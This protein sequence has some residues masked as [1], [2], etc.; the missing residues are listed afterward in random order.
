VCE[1]S[2]GIRYLLYLSEDEQGKE[3]HYLIDR[4]NDF[5]LNRNTG[6]H[7]PTPED[8]VNFH[9]D[10]L[11][12]G[13]LVFDMEGDTKVPRFLLFDCLVIDGKNI[14]ERSLDKRLAYMRQHL[15]QPYKK[16]FQVFPHELKFQPFEVRMKDM[17]LGYGME[18]M[19]KEVLPKLKHGNDGLI[20]TCRTTPY[21]H[22][23]DPHILKWKPPEEN[24][25][26]CRLKLFFPLIQPDEDDIA[27][28]WTEPYHDYHTLEHAEIWAFMGNGPN[29]YQ[30][31][32]DLH[33]T[34]EEFDE[35][36]SLGDPIQDRIVEC[37]QDEAGR[38][39]I[40]RF[41]DD[42]AEANHIST[43][44]SVMRSIEDRVTQQDL[45][46]VAKAVKDA[47]KIRNASGQRPG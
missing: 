47:W 31:F 11:L 43:L 9:R 16:L 8:H 25:V 18:M 32:A 34:E 44:N 19:F 22:G 23:T 21:R 38:W 37:Y 13:E 6:L 12:D 24:T 2:D 45:L 15:Y 10:T 39:R 27:E 17:Q 26:D 42:K 41:R 46:H 20:F 35:L 14:M 7:F 40:S 5:F 4:K 28:G 29:P 1:K 36:I 33:I 3:A 30:K